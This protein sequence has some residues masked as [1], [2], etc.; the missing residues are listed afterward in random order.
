MTTPT[1]TVHIPRDVGN[2]LAKIQK[3]QQALVSRLGHPGC[4]SGFN[5]LFQQ[6]VEFAVNPASL[7]L[8]PI[9]R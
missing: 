8:S 9:A 4:Y 7:E 3:I 2:D 1:I 5:I 6:E